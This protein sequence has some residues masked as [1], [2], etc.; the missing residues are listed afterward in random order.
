ML[1][2]YQ[3]VEY[4]DAMVVLLPG[5]FVQCQKVQAK[6]RWSVIW[7]EYKSDER[8]VHGEELFMLFKIYLFIVRMKTQNFGF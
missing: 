8:E 1:D 2:T 4:L 6:K 7:R 3:C 5:V